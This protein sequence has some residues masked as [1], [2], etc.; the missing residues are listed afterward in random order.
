MEQIPSDEEVRVASLADRDSVVAIADDVHHGTDSLPATYPYLVKGPSI[1]GYLYKKG[2]KTIAFLNTQ[3]IDG[4]KT[5]L[6]SAARV[7]EEYRGSGVLG[8]FHRLIR[9]KYIGTPKLCY[10]AFAVFDIIMATIGQKLLKTNRHVTEKTLTTV[11][12]TS[13]DVSF[14]AATRFPELKMLCNDDMT[15]I[16]SCE[17]G[18][19][20]HLFPDGRIILDQKPYRLMAA[21]V[22]LITNTCTH[23]VFLATDAKSPP[24]DT[25]LLSVPTVL[26]AGSYFACSKGTWYIT[27]VYGEGSEEE[28]RAH[29]TWHLLRSADVGNGNV[30][31]SIFHTRGLADFLTDL[32]KTFPLRTS[33][34]SYKKP[35]VFEEEFCQRW[36]DPVTIS[37]VNSS[38][39]IV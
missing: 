24:L 16:M 39:P 8:R 17:D 13:F 27:D 28:L 6:Y 31:F 14:K 2:G 11:E 20:R 26:S 19:L 4:G 38:H 15:S 5:L 10:K 30:V 34:V 1:R 7:S 22:P 23:R 9:N 12:L 18:R 29:I 35:I 3:L 21:N 33:S 36:N 25:G 32:G 37:H